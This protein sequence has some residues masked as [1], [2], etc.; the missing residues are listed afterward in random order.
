MQIRT[1]LSSYMAVAKIS[2]RNARQYTVDFIT[3]FFYF[4]AELVAL[5][6]IY[7]LVYWQIWQ[8]EGTTVIGGFNLLQLISYLFITLTIQKTLPQSRMSR[9]IERDI[10]QGPLVAY[11]SKPVDYAGYRFFRELPRSLIYLFFGALTYIAGILLFGL[12]IPNPLNLTLFIPLFLA[13]YT[14][15]FLL[16]FTLSLLTFWIGRQW[17]FRNLVNLLTLIA[18]GGLIPLTFFPT[19]I[20]QILSLL[21]F[22]YCYF[23]PVTVL[24]GFYNPYQLGPV[25][26]MDAI[27]LVI[28]YAMMRL[29]WSRGRHRYEGAGG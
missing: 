18:G 9:E 10:D 19:S 13:A 23:I 8:S 12:I 17:W 26:L 21:P 1:K 27:W 2:F 3:H 6:F 25:I 15:T 14:I 4:P 29:V 24:Q 28:L 7:S 20:Q 22:Q 11:L 5:F 16:V